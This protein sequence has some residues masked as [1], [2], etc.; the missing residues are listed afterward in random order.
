MRQCLNAEQERVSG[1]PRIAPA[2]PRPVGGRARIGAPALLLLAVAVVPA[3]SA[4]SNELS[5]NEPSDEIPP[6]PPS[7]TTREV[8]RSGGAAEAGGVE[9]TGRLVAALGPGERSVVVDLVARRVLLISPDGSLER[10]LGRP[11]DGPGELRQPHRAGFLGDSLVWVADGASA[12]VTLYHLDGTV[13]ETLPAPRGPLPESHGWITIGVDWLLEGR[14]ALLRLDL[15]REEV[16]LPIALADSVGHV[17]V[18][19]RVPYRPPFVPVRVGPGEMYMRQPIQADPIV[20]AS[21]DG[22]WFFV[23]D[24]EP[25]TRERAELVVRRFDASGAELAP[26]RI[27]Y[28]ARPAGEGTRAWIEAFVRSWVDQVNERSTVGQVDA[29]EALSK[30]WVPTFLPPV[31]AALGDSS[32]FWLQWEQPRD[33]EA[34]AESLWDRYDLEGRLLSRV[35]V[36][37]GAAVL[38][39]D[40]RSLLAYALDS[41][42]VPIL[43]LHR[44]APAGCREE[45]ER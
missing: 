17:R 30:A 18:L 15:L 9:L 23:L 7:T 2:G 29:D 10:V 28:V 42:R 22:R 19:D 38:A 26:V 8:W 35:T 1:A 21:A 6:A 13:R 32:G 12:R 16:T 3:C 45:E 34:P 37:S 20:A 25:A 44:V 43:T 33:M 4:P 40:P 11:G 14:A 36:P 27:P 39:G 31:R 5:D 24:R 41:L